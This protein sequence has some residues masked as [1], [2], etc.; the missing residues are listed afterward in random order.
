[1]TSQLNIYKPGKQ[2]IVSN[3]L[4]CQDA[5]E[6]SLLALSEITFPIFDHL[7]AEITTNEEAG[8]LVQSIRTGQLSPA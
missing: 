1:M 2:N 6:P 3:A 7:K 4:S 8:K 5:I